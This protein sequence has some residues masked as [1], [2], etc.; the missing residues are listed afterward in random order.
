MNTRGVVTVTLNPAL[1]MT[2]ALGELKPGLV[3]LIGSSNLNPGG[4]GVNVA[5]V[6]AELGA[7]VTVTGFLGDENQDP[8]AH[9]FEQKGIADRFVRVA[10][11]SRINVKL[12]EESGRVTDLNFPGVTVSDE[13][14]DA[15]EAT[16]NELAEE[17]DLFVIA[18]SLPG[19]VSPAMLASWI[20]ML[21]AK[22]KK[23]LFDSSNA[24]LT[25]GLKASPW[26]V[27]PNDEELSQWVGKA[28]ESEDELL[29][30]GESLS[31]TGIDNVVIS[32]GAEGVLW[33]RDGKWLQSQPPRMKV[34]S[35][36]GAGDTLVAGMCWAELNQWDREVS[37]S[38]AT[39]LSALAVTQVNVG[40]EDIAHVEA[41]QREIIVKQ[42]KQD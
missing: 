26:L 41:L 23:V 10:G 24:A 40:V 17:N 20:E 4:K 18:G 13:D 12:V 31:E 9:L 33:L 36:V 37:L 19:G 22:G 6:L 7:K 25:A 8:F 42:L 28:L 30:T 3:N 11:A 1:D 27:K 29:A 39:A 32:R 16:L 14:L 21:R 5:K 35:T 15:F 2:G 38:F 34:V